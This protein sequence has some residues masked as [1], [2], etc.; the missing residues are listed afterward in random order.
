M[1]CRDDIPASA[2]VAETMDLKEQSRT[3]PNG[4]CYM[5]HLWETA[6]ESKWKLKIVLR[7]DDELF[8]DVPVPVHWTHGRFEWMT[9]S[10]PDKSN[11]VVDIPDEVV[12]RIQSKAASD[13]TRR[14]FGNTWAANLPKAIVDPNAQSR[15]WYR[16][17]GPDTQHVVIEDDWIQILEAI[18]ATAED[19]DGQIGGQT[20]KV[21]TGAGTQPAYARVQDG[22]LE[23]YIGHLTEVLA[24]PW[25]ADLLHALHQ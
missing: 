3:N 23:V 11:L 19:P 15:D 13:F 14:F 20:L 25:R 16:R 22:R 1:G 10:Q 18:K 2:V 12:R 9:P 17:Y 7:T 21:Y 8:D 6:N 24:R 4:V 5:D